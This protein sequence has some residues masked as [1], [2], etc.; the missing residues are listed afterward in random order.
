MLD[1]GS[2]LP[3]ISSSNEASEAS[4]ANKAD[5]TSSEAE[6]APAVD[7]VLSK[8]PNANKWTVSFIRFC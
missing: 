6:D 2:S 3:R 8:L 5:A 4:N 1:N 7:E